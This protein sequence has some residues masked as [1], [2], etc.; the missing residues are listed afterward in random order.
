MSFGQLASL[1]HL[2]N[3]DDKAAVYPVHQLNSV[4][5]TVVENV[6]STIRRHEIIKYSKGSIPLFLIKKIGHYD[7][8]QSQG[9][10]EIIMTDSYLYNPNV[11]G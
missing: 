8:Y 4:S 1:Y 9:R 10:Q 7:F 6:D 3:V 11:I 2:L 5:R